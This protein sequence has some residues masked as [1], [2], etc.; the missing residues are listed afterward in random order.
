MGTWVVRLCAKSLVV[1]ACVTQLSVAAVGQEEATAPPA[2]V[3]KGPTPRLPDGKPDFSGLWNPDR[4]FI[5][6]LADALKPGES[7]PLQPWALKLTENRS[8]S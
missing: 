6:D 8:N 7:L 5:Y 4:N 3:P 2:A 1:A